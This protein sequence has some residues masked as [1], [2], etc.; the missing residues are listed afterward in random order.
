MRRHFKR[1]TLNNLL[2]IA[3]D[4]MCIYFQFYV[5]SLRKYIQITNNYNQVIME[6]KFTYLQYVDANASQYI[7]LRMFFLSVRFLSSMVLLQ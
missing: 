4:K 5:I 6:T 1:Y 7:Q 3:E 2:S